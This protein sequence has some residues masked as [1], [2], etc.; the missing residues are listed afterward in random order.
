MR[1]IQFCT[2]RFLS[3]TLIA[4]ICTAPLSANGSW[5]VKPRD[6]RELSHLYS[7]DPEERTLTTSEP[8]APCDSF[9]SEIDWDQLDT[10][11]LDRVFDSSSVPVKTEKKLGKKPIAKKASLDIVE[12]L[13]AEES[14]ADIIR[15]TDEPKTFVS[16]GKIA[17]LS[18]ESLLAQIQENASAPPKE[19]PILISF[20][21][22]S[23]VEYVRFISRVSNKNFIFSE[24]DLQFTVTI[25][26]EE[27]TTIENVLMALFQELRIRGLNVLEEGNTI[28]IHK[29]DNVRAPGTVVSDLF[30]L[31]G[32]P[33][34]NIIT[35]VFRLNIADAQAVISMIRP[36]LS[37]KSVIQV[38][39]DTNH[40]ILTDI[41]SNI[42]KVSQ[43][44]KS[45]DAPNSSMVVG[46]YVVRNAYLDDLI[47]NGEQIMNS[48]ARGQPVTFVSHV[49]SNSI[50][51][52]A[53]PFLVERAIPILQRLDQ[54][55]GTTGIFDLNDLKYIP[56]S[57]AEEAGRLGRAR[58]S[59]DASMRILPDGT[60]VYQAPSSPGFWKL[61]ANGNWIYEPTGVES[62]TREDSSKPPPGFWRQ[63]Y[64]N[65]WEFVQGE[66]PRE[67]RG[68][69]LIRSTTGAWEYIGAEGKTP[70]G[71][72]EYGGDGKWRFLL[73]PGASIFAG[74]RVR[75]SQLETSLPLGDIERTKFYIH[76]LQYRKGD[77]IQ[78]AM[79]QI[80][81]SLSS[82][83]TVNLE[84]IQAIES[85]QWLEPSNS[86][87]ITGTP[88]ALIKLRELIDEI[89]RPLRQVFIEMLVLDLNIV[90]ALAL[91]V[92]WGSKFGGGNT[93]GGQA[94][95]SGASVVPALIAS[96]GR[97]VAAAAAAAAAAIPDVAPIFGVSGYTAGIVGQRLS[98][99]GQTF[100]TFAAF[101]RALHDKA[102]VN[103]LLNPKILTEDNLT[104]ELF[105]GQNTPFKTQS[106]ANDQGSTITSNFE[107]KDV[108][109]TLKVTP[110]LGNS[111]IVTIELEFE[112]S[113]VVPGTGQGSGLSDQP[114][115]PTTNISRTKTRIH[116]P[117]GYFLVISGLIRN[118]ESRNRR[119]VPCLGGIPILGAAFT[120]KDYRL[121]KRNL[122]MFL[123]PQIIDTEI[124]MDNLTSHQQ[125][126]LRVHQK[127][128]RMWKF[129]YEETLDWLNG[130]RTD[131]NND[132]RECCQ[133]NDIWPVHRDHN[134]GGSHRHKR[135]CE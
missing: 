72:W 23:V 26:S 36:I 87:I 114:I 4:S 74:K 40:I 34:A 56:P 49:P 2:L 64:Q 66:S 132:E 94:F 99:D 12:S 13:I 43:L 101:L 8:H 121:E 50:F 92:S 18:N 103:V 108:G 38:L 32:R 115:G 79:Q 116:M 131:D 105:I 89:D 112:Q 75:T 22:I 52:I 15:K 1:R 122:M 123:R 17:R 109:T 106:I 84:L 55:D 31:N 128:K 44:I 14:V 24:E 48:I 118:S 130:I 97:R 20:N 82:T 16:K 91:G 78:Q 68:Q 65:H 86:L 45:V 60:Q 134:K 37:D 53:A 90:D 33:N 113:E 58:V 21:N 119:Q 11:S 96:S 100:Q 102:N 19:E 125:N 93:A 57:S 69:Q 5:Q 59:P 80:G 76:K 111:N 117:D 83:Q 67:L 71:K 25:V 39:T 77:S 63:D 7:I 42:D 10:S 51:I 85:T 27:T 104:A 124:E 9:E 28:L 126:L 3:F 107:F 88:T 135:L 46:Q 127:T 81:A 70:E 120:D 133:E 47:T 54:N 62:A 35:R 61:D 29:T 95:I 6:E 30:P 98:S 129:E 73:K 110:Y 41:A